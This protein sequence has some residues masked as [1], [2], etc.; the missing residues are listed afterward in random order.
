[1]I[2]HRIRVVS[3]NSRGRNA[4][5]ADKV[6]T[7]KPRRRQPGRYYAS[8]IRL[9]AGQFEVEVKEEGEGVFLFLHPV[10][11]A[12]GGVEGGLG[13][14]QAVGAGG[15]EG[16]IEVAQGPAVGGYDLA[17]GAPK[18]SIV[19]TDTRLSKWTCR[20]RPKPL[21]FCYERG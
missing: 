6:P 7:V 18:M 5:C 13:V 3:P 11:G 8:A 4:V 21:V 20:T 12:D 1:M 10:G 17:V 16:A 14:A 9:A 19:R 15:F 2:V